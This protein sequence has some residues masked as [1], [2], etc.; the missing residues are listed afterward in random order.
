MF[1]KNVVPIQVGEVTNLY[2][3]KCFEEMI[4]KYVRQVG[5]FVVR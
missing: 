1:G 4:K 2:C 5:Q 3:M